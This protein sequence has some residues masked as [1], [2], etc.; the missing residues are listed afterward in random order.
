MTE[1]YNRFVA[2]E[3]E[4]G[5]ESEEEEEYRI[6][7]RKNANSPSVQGKVKVGRQEIQQ[8]S[9][10]LQQPPQEQLIISDFM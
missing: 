5:E 6:G 10:H 3:E 7:K 2:P 1:Y 4:E 8:Q 9:S